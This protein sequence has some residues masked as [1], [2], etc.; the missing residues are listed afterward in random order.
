MIDNRVQ[1]HIQRYFPEL[2]DVFRNWEGKIALFTLREFPFPS[3]LRHLSPEEVLARWKTVVKRGVG[4]KRAT[5]L[6]EKTNF[7]Q[8][9]S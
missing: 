9:G 6:I 2:T 1:N 5:N 3:D 4:I 8:I 7:E